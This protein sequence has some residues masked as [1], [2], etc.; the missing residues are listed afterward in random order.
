MALQGPKRDLNRLE[1]HFWPHKSAQ[2][3][4]FVQGW[5]TKNVIQIDQF[6]P[7]DTS[8]MSQM[9]PYGGQRGAK[10]GKKNAKLV[11]RACFGLEG[12]ERGWNTNED[13]QTDQFGQLVMPRIFQMWPYGHKMGTN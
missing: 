7:Y 10:I 12:V 5:N 9:L 13:I 4:Y 11:Q 1:I 8:R 6:G 3:V 2:R